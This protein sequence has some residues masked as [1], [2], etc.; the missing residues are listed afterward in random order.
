MIS[1]IISEELRPVAQKVA[2]V[3]TTHNQAH[4]LSDAID[5]CLL[6]TVA[7]DEIIVV[8]DGSTDDPASIVAR[9]SKVRMIR[10]KNS[11]ISAARNTGIAATDAVFLTFLDA[12]D[13]LLPEA[14]HIGIQHLEA[15]P[16]AAM[17]YGAYRVIDVG[18]RPVS[19]KI[20]V[21]VLGNSYLRFL[22]SGN[23][24]SMHA[25]VVY[26]HE[27]LAALGGFDESFCSCEDY[28]LFLRVAKTGTIVSHE[29]LVAEYRKHGQN[30][31]NNREMM[32]AGALRALIG[33][34]GSNVSAESRV[35]IAEG[36]K[37]WTDYYAS[38]L[39]NDVIR[40][41]KSHPL[42]AYKAIFQ[43]LRMAPWTFFKT[44][45]SKGKHRLARLY[46]NRNWPPH[47]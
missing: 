27:R 45:A 24:I 23:F 46:A 4:F 3:I 18:G 5:S 16:S 21:P 19:T 40:N 30:T 8:D 9:Y 36:R 14:M 39:A 35:A 13:R 26:R 6:Q 20:H 28:E 10:Q 15:Q 29:C 47:A 1:S 7:V 44:I 33:Q 42:K 12:D 22:R 17:V 2:I 11:G 31:S 41:F 34:L 43:A 25:T 38:E 37:F 32:L